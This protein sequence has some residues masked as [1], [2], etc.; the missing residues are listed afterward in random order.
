MNDFDKSNYKDVYLSIY[1]LERLNQ[2]RL[3]YYKLM[4]EWL[5]DWNEVIQLM[6]TTIEEKSIL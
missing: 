6:C 1:T 3:R 2:F 5:I 4:G